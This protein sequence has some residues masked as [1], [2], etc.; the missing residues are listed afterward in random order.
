MDGGDDDFWID[1]AEADAF[2][3]ARRRA[4][5][6]MDQPIPRDV[7]RAVDEERLI[8]LMEIEVREIARARGIPVEDMDGAFERDPL[9]GEY[10]WVDFSGPYAHGP[11]KF[12]KA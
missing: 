2:Q 7:E 8:D 3:G 9:T 6:E 10:Y 4:R 11:S 5:D 12:A 1:E